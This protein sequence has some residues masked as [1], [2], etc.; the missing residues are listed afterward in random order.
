MYFELREPAC[1]ISLP[2]SKG[3]RRLVPLL[4][5]LGFAAEVRA[6]PQGLTVSSGTASVAGSGSQL[7][8]TVSQNAVLNW[9][10]FNIAPGQTTSFLQPSAASIVWNRINDV[11]PSQIWGNLNANGIVVLMNQSG[12]FFGPGSVVNAAGFVATTATTLPDFGVGGA[13]QFSGPPPAASIVNYGE[14]RVHSGS[15]AFL[16]AEKIEN[17]GLLMAPDGTLGLYA[18]KEVLMSERPDGRGLSVQVQ[19]PEGSVD[20]QGKLVADGGSILIHAQTVNQNGILQ[21]NS[22]RDRNGVIELLA[23]DSVN[24]GANS[25]I[26]A[27]GDATTVSSGGKVTVKSDGSFTDATGS[28]VTVAGSALGGN[29]GE[30][31]LSAPFMAAIHSSVDGHAAAGYIGGSLLIDPT[32]INIGTSGSGSANSGTVLAG[33]PPTTLNLD[34]NSAFVGLANIDLQARRNITVLSGTAWDLVQSTG[35]S[36]GNHMLSLEAGNNITLQAGSSIQAG[37]G[38]SVSLAA[39]R[40]FSSPDTLKPN[41]GNILFQSSSALVAHD[42]SVALRAGNNITLQGGTTWAFDHSAG[43]STLAS[44][45]SAEAG[46]NI[47]IQ[48]SSIQAGQGWSVSLAAGRDFSTL[49]DVT[50]GV[51]SIV[52]QN[53]GSLQASAGAVT[54]RAGQDVT[55]A[56]GFV[57]TVGGGSIDVTAVSG[58]IYTGTKVNGF[59]FLATDNLSLNNYMLVDPDL[60]GIS[61]A[62]GGNVNL[63]AGL[64]ITSYLPNNN[65]TR[66]R[67]TDGGSG[68]F[69]IEP[70]NVTLNA[71]GDVTGH[72]VVRN[73]EGVINAGVQIQNGQLRV[74]NPLADAGTASANLALSLVKGGW[75]VSAPQDIF[76][77]EVRNPNGIYNDQGF[78][79]RIAAKH[80]FDYAPDAYVDLTAGNSVELTGVS[81][82]TLPR[83]SATFEQGIPAIYAPCLNISAGAG[84]VLIADDIVLFP[85]PVGQLSIKTTDGGS[86]RGTRAGALVSLTMSDS[87][88]T[89]YKP[90]SNPNADFGASDHAPTPLHVNDPAPV[91]LD[92]SGDIGPHALGDATGGLLLV[93]PKH[94]EITVGGNMVNSRFDIQN[95]HSSDV[96]KLNVAGDILN[97]VQFTGVPLAASPDFLPLTRVVDPSLANLA[98]KFSYNSQTHTLTFNGAMTSTEMNALISLQVY[99][100][101]PATQ[102]PLLDPTTHMPVIETVSIL[103]LA[104]AQALFDATQNLPQSPDTGY[105]IG[106][107]GT[108]NLTARNLN[109]GATTG[110]R[111]VGPAN[112]PGLARLGASG[113]TINVNVLGNLDMFSTAIAS[114]AGGNIVVNVGGSANLGSSV[115]TGDATPRGIFTVGKSDVSVTAGGDINISGSRIA[116]YDGG[117]ITVLSLNGNVNA[118]Q[119]GQGAVEVEQVYVDPITGRVV[120]Y[121]PTIPGSGILATS[122]PASLDSS[123]PSSRNAPGNITVLTPHGNIN[124]SAGGIVQIALNNVDSRTASVTLTAGGS[125]D[126]RGSGVI[127]NNVHLEAAGGVQG[128]VV[129]QHDISISA[130]QNV[131]VTAIGSGNVNVSSAGGAVSGMIVGVGNVSVSG[132]SVDAAMLSQGGVSAN[133]ANVGSS[134]A[135]TSA[136]AAG[137]T[138]QSTAA[139]SEQ[140][141]KKT[142]VANTTDDEDEKK[143]RLPGSGP[144]VTRRTGR[145]TVILPKS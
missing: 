130:Q 93:F 120:T 65:S 66:I 8:I 103:S 52:F 89:Q 87:A 77:Q 101:D 127:G 135:F 105:T 70:G 107:P 128:L 48:S 111:S 20:N 82:S 98:G 108:L 138:S 117:N 109:L 94:A 19:L 136:N 126:A 25:L 104:T 64:D 56:S 69:G 129:A 13:W 3:L 118:G 47:S 11:N 38:W 78:T 71:G 27:Q 2:W 62:A 96:T 55:V 112:N 84:G 131:S 59:I 90:A 15:S 9:Q 75:A 110:I 46:N 74:V 145:V 43:A 5:A 51:G 115:S 114:F 44:L 99:A 68:A 17:H 91:L 83:K 21:A 39:G 119:G 79:G 45:V 42:G 6:N 80:F 139:S 132:A 81:G 140:Q 50:P 23:S 33:D 34:V 100:L 143:K 58:S 16:I 24:L 72:Y 95:L 30:V 85:S 37:L 60:G 36:G 22:V 134:A 142:V 63:T 41:F 137:S 18:G 88:S 1:A 116:A 31:E 40:D 14:I 53:T 125:I 124:A 61:T 97:T 122:F 92:I 86:L 7:N 76:L 12:F 28:H 4:F 106:G 57:R 73:G 10:S 121:T 67:A 123:F 35:V 54:L 133:N 113:A 49:T 102:K 141:L 144:V 26:T 32:D 29:G